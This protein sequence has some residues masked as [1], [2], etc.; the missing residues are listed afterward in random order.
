MNDDRGA[1]LARHY[2]GLIDEGKL[3]ESVDLFA[4]GAEYRRPGHDPFVG[5][6]AIAHF[7]CDLRPIREGAHRLT[8]VLQSGDEVAV[9]G[10]FH[11][12][13]NDGSDIHL[14]FADFFRVGQDGFD[15]RE[16]FFF[17]PLV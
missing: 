9:A 12:R 1:E 2:F 14:K 16:T 7:Y 4:P 5:R 6:D 15:R 10:E 13:M 17:A 3:R 11:G 8:T